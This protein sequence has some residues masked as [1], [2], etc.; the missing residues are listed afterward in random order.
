MTISDTDRPIISVRGI[1]R[2]FAAGGSETRS[3]QRLNERLAR[4]GIEPLYRELS[5][6]DPTAA[7]RLHPR[8]PG[9][10][11]DAGAGSR[12]VPQPSMRP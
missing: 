3:R 9:R 5:I 8:W 6:I 4:E 2:S 10:H 11:A 1:S 7:A 12:N